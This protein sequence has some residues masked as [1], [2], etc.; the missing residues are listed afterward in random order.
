MTPQA[1]SYATIASTGKIYA[2]PY[3][4]TECVNYM[5]KIDAKTYHIEKISLIN[6]T[7]TERWTRGI[8]Y[9][10]FLYFLPFNEDC[11]LCIN[12]QNDKIEYIDINWPDESKK[13]RGKYISFHLYKNK[14]YSLPYGE[15][16]P[17]DHV[18]VFDPITKN[19]DFIKINLDI[20]DC[21]KWHTSQILNNTIYAV[22]RG[23]RW[24]NNYFP[25][26]IEFNCD[27]FDY[28]LNDFSLFWKEIDQ[29]EFSN[30]KY[31]TLAKSNEKLYALPYSENPNFD[32]MLKFDKEWTAEKTG[33]TADSR[34][35]F[36][37][38]T[39]ANGKIYSPPAGHKED[40]CEMLIIDPIIDRWYKK[41]LYIGKESKKYFTG[42]ENSQGKIYFMPRG[43]CACSPVETWKQ[44]GD[45]AEILVVDTKDDSHYTIDISQYFLDN[46][47]IEKY[48]CCVIIDDKIY[49]FP[50]G[51]SETFH[52]LLVFDTK[53]EKVI[54]AIDL[55]D[56]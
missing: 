22:P 15:K 45:L 49:A 46:T 26:G 37:S 18:I 20:N 16:S 39:A 47:T 42:V 28:K 36:A 19:M 14:I 23:E 24:K 7:K 34:K 17:F 8:E 33:L 53:I 54:K 44:F 48:N 56:I 3:G 6:S 35:Y 52:T 51:E 25:Y 11:I 9:N 21:K 1:F 2:P 4:L 13:I 31:T 12:L 5:L 32:V 10:G 55:N 40:W 29:Q 50:Y 38:V 41:D 30:K 43:G 27:T